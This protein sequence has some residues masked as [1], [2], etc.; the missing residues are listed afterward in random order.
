MLA[1]LRII[2]V[3]E[4]RGT[5]MLEV[6]GLVLWHNLTANRFLSVWIVKCFP[7]EERNVL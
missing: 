6:P 4:Q 1:H 5:R 2:E 7:A 3:K